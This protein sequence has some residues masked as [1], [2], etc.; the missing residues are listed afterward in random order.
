MARHGWRASHATAGAVGNAGRYHDRIMIWQTIFPLGWAHYLLGGLCLGVG[1]G[2]LFLFTGRVGG[3]SSVFTSTWSFFSHGAFFQQ[4]KWL[5]SRNWRL[6]YALGLIVG[7]FAWWL[8]KGG[9]VPES[10]AVPWWL[11]LLGGFIVGYGARLGHGCTS[12]HGIC[13]IGSLQWPSALA[14]CTFYVTAILAANLVTRW[15]V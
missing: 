5:E 12:G 4:P 15:F 8:W 1:V 3:M 10:T 6:L 7:A 2:F 11:L 9:G 13:G 14:V